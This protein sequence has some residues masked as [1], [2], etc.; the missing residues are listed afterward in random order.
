MPKAPQE[1][2]EL[3]VSLDR[4]FIPLSHPARWEHH[5]SPLKSAMKLGVLWTSQSLWGSWAQLL[6]YWG[7]RLS[8]CLPG[9]L[10]GGKTRQAQARV[11]E[12]ASE[13]EKTAATSRTGPGALIWGH[14][15]LCTGGGGQITPC[16]GLFLSLLLMIYSQPPLD[17]TVGLTLAHKV[18]AKILPIPT[19]P[20]G[21][22]TAQRGERA[23]WARS[24]LSSV[25]PARFSLPQSPASSSPAP[26]HCPGSCFL[27]LSKLCPTC[28][29]LILFPAIIS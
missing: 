24:G 13:T 6:F 7:F 26:L 18:T 9:L 23:P 19:S 21:N 5:C 29:S 1:I 22:R 4:H 8:I 28:L 25:S 14:S 15:S 2:R 12:Q 10:L 3:R 11:G 17:P 16:S 20:K 27:L